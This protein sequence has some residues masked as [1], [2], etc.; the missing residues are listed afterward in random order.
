MEQILNS[1][2]TLS[3]CFHSFQLRVFEDAQL[4]SHLQIHL[5]RGKGDAAPLPDEEELFETVFAGLLR[6]NQDFREVS[7]IFQRSQVKVIVHEHETGPF[8]GRDIRIK[9]NYIAQ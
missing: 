2:P 3:A 5:E 7:R 8:A 9:N 4:T 6:V 1:D